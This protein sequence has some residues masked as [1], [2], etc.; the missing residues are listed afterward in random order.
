MVTTINLRND[1]RISAKLVLTITDAIN[2][3]D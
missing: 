3:G 2:F 1:R